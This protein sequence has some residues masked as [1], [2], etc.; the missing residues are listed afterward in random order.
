M[1]VAEL[2][3]IVNICVLTVSVF[4][5]VSTNFCYILP[6]L[7]HCF[8]CIYY[9]SSVSIVFSFDLIHFG[10]RFEVLFSSE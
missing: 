1:K 5:L 9:C 3:T 7:L 2:L 8:K 4:F 10:P 6:S